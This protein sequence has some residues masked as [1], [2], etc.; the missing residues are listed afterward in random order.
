MKQIVRSSAR[1]QPNQADGSNGCDL[2]PKT[3]RAPM[4]V[5]SAVLSA[6]TAAITGTVSGVPT[7]AD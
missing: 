2:P 5:K 4:L 3:Y 6:V 1:L 7:T